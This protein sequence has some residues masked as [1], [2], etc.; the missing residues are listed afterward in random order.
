MHESLSV[1][2]FFF[3]CV[4]VWVMELFLP[5]HDMH[6]LDL[7][8]QDH[9]VALGALREVKAL[10]YIMDHK[11]WPRILSGWCSFKMRA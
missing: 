11:Q 5:H 8:I 2:F 9:S 6:L 1:I 3:L 4:C 10:S 7:R